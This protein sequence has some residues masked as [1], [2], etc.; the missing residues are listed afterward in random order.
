MT[1]FYIWL[2]VV[3]VHAAILI[4]VR[5][6]PE[7][8]LKLITPRSE[9]EDFPN[10]YRSLDK[11]INIIIILVCIVAPYFISKLFI[12]IAG[13]IGYD[14]LVCGIIAYVIFLASISFVYKIVC[15]FFP[16]F[17]RF[18]AAYSKAK[19][20]TTPN[21]YAT[22][23]ERLAAPIEADSLFQTYILSFDLRKLSF[24]EWWKVCGI[25]LCGWLIAGLALI[26]IYWIQ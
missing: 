20:I 19:I 7:K 18:Q 26:Y 10:K 22:K 25:S 16:K 8:D 1:I 9:A 17:D 2:L 21:R 4:L 11:Y 5:K 6:Y 12:S 23:A 13:S 14:P 15:S 3:I 24:N